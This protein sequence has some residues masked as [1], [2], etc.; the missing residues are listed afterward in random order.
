M[1]SIKLIALIIS[2]L[3][4]LASCSDP[5]DPSL[6]KVRIKYIWTS[7]IDYSQYTFSETSITFVDTMYKVG[8][9]VRRDTRRFIIVN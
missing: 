5:R 6:K 2:I 1:N 9:T 8:D 3:A 7:T 4:L